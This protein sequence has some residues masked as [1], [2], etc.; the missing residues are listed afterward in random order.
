MNNWVWILFGIIVL[1]HGI[2]HILFLIPALGV[3]DWGQSTRSWL[4]TKPLGDGLTRGFGALLWLAVTI[5]F[6]AGVIGLFNHATWWQPVLVAASAASA[7]GLILFWASPAS[8]SAIFALVV[9]IGIILA[10]QV[11]HWPSL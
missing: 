1:V 4:L 9:D 10:V 11:F 5:A 6:V 8:S 3:A 7:L 2:G